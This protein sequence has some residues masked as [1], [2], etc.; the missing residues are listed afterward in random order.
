MTATLRTIVTFTSS[1]FITPRLD[2][3]TSSND[4]CFGDDVAKWLIERLT[5]AGFQTADLP[6][7]E[8]FGWYFNFELD[9]VQHCFVVGYRP[10]VSNEAGTWIGWLE[11]N[12]SFVPSLFGARGRSILPEAAHAIQK[13]LSGDPSIQNIRWHFKEDFDVGNEAVGAPKPE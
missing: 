12:R 8:D 1:R 4:G 5:R 13:V 11:R 3:T 7:Q 10:G 6:G 9:G 2:T